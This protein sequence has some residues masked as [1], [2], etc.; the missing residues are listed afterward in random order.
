MGGRE[1]TL[2]LPGGQA[3]MLSPSP[4]LYS[5]SSEREQRTH[6]MRQGSRN[7]RWDHAMILYISVPTMS[8]ECFHSKVN[9]DATNVSVGLTPKVTDQLGTGHRHIIYLLITIFHVVR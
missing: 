1:S 5:L 2:E 7:L 6:L 8:S 3:G 4:S 9:Q